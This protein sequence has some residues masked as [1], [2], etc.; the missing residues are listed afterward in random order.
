VEGGDVFGPHGGGIGGRALFVSVLFRW[1]RGIII[2]VDFA[3]RGRAGSGLVALVLVVAVH[4]G[5]LELGESDSDRGN[6]E[7]W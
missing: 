3:G 4:G 7:M 6:V 2:G 1:R 5:V